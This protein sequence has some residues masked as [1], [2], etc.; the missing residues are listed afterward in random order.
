MDVDTRH[1]D[2]VD[3]FTAEENSEVKACMQYRS[4]VARDE[5]ST[6]ATIVRI[7]HLNLNIG[8]LWLNTYQQNHQT[9][10]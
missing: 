8:V 5:C 9:L 1:I 3:I 10:Q 2:N 6:A 4:T 7:M